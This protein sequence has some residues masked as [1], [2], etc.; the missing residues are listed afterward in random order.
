KI[1]IFI[2]CFWPAKCPK[3]SAAT[4][5][6]LG[7]VCLCCASTTSEK[8]RSACGRKSHGSKLK[9]NESVFYKIFHT[10]SLLHY[11]PLIRQKRQRIKRTTNHSTCRP[12]AA[13]PQNIRTTSTC[14]FNLSALWAAFPQQLSPLDNTITNRSMGKPQRN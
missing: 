3:A 13:F 7:S 2:S 10:S 12:S 1:C 6:N 8:Y 9:K 4:S 14:L 5:A 11:I